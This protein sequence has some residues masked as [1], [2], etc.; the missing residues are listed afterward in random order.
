M[1]LKQLEEWIAE[2]VLRHHLSKVELNAMATTYATLFKAYVYW[3]WS[4][5]DLDF[6]VW[7]QYEDEGDG[8]LRV[9]MEEMYDNMIDAWSNRLDVKG[10]E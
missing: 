5:S 1:G 3:E 6:T 7:E 9:S 2:D 4:S 10:G 8:G